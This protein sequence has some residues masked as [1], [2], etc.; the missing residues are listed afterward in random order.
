MRIVIVVVVGGGGPSSQK[1]SERL[2][3][4]RMRGLSTMI[5]RLQYMIVAAV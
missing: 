1:V 5:I 2:R 4:Q 3:N